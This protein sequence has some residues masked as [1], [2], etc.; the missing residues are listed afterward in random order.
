MSNDQVYDTL[1]EVHEVFVSW[2]AE[3]KTRDFACALWETAEVY[4]K[5]EYGEQL[6]TEQRAN[7]VFNMLLSAK[8]L[9][10]CLTENLRRLIVRYHAHNISTTTAVEAILLDEEMEHITPF[11]LLKYKNVCGFVNIKNFLVRRLGYLKPWHPRWAKKYNGVWRE[12]RAN[13]VDQI[14]DIPLSQPKEQLQEL[15]NHYQE[16]REQY[17]QAEKAIDKERYHKSMVRTMGAIHTITRDP[18]IQQDIAALPAAEK[19]KALAKPE[20]EITIEDV[21]AQEQELKRG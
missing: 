18:S 1:S 13:F 7:Q 21:A 19:P 11:Y 5:H 17:N 16:L 20:Q 4:V 9:T 8:S 10:R 12:E 14:M 2:E 6:T 3:G 15:S